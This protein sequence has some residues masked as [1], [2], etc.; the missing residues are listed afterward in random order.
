VVAGTLAGRVRHAGMTG[1]PY[2]LDRFI[3]A[4]DQVYPRA[5][6]EIKQGRKTRHW[7]WF[8]FPQMAGLGHSPMA[9][10]YAISGLAEA[11]AYLGHPVLGARLAEI[12]EALQ[13]LPPTSAEAVF[14]SIDAVKLR[15]CLTLFG[16]VGGGPLFDA[17][18]HRWFGG[19]EDEAT[20]RLIGP[21]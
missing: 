7:M 21:G 17:A 11:R 15:S 18:L 1:D 5:L 14:G 16:R 12:V 19:A 3:R 20:L 4:Q 10:R 8:V 2:Q 6:D 13:A 9:Q